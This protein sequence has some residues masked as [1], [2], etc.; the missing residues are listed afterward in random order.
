[1]PTVA[2][3]RRTGLADL[4]YVGCLALVYKYKRDGGRN[5]TRPEVYFNNLHEF[6]R[7]RVENVVSQV[8]RHRL[9]K[10]GAFSGSMDHLTPL[11]KIVGHVTA[12]EIRKY[13]PRFTC[14]GP[15]SHV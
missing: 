10:K 15:W 1:M 7:N 14:Y 5:L 3:S 8:K 2:D 4:G 9:F 11:V 12:Y 6:I 13:G